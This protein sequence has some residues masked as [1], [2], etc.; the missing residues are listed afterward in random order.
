MINLV[1]ISMSIVFDVII[2]FVDTMSTCTYLSDVKIEIEMRSSPAN[3]II[4][5]MVV[6]MLFWVLID[7]LNTM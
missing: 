3:L 2:P 6:T 4:L 5:E 1:F 7:C